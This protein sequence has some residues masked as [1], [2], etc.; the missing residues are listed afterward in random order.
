MTCRE[1]F[2]NA[3]EELCYNGGMKIKNVFKIEYILI[4]LS[5]LI[6]AFT[7]FLKTAS[8]KKYDELNVLINNLVIDC[9]NDKITDL[10]IKLSP[11]TY[12]SGEIDNQFNTLSELLR[13]S[14]SQKE[15]IFAE[16][17]L[18]EDLIRLNQKSINFGYDCLF[19]SSFF[20]L[21]ISVVLVLYKA[22]SKK[23]ELLRQQSLNEAKIKFSQ[24]L[25]D[26]VA[27]DLA[28]LKL[29]IQNDEKSK[30]VYYSEQAFK[31]VRYLIESTHLDFNQNFE[32]ILQQTLKSFEVNFGIKTEF[33]CASNL[34]KSLAPETQMEL[35]RI[36]QEALSNTSRHSEASLLTVKI[37]DICSFIRFIIED[38]GKGFSEAEI[39]GKKSEEKKHYGLENIRTRVEKLG[40]TV[41]ISGKGGT[42]IAITIKNIVH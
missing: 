11:F 31:E 19:I 40:G 26:G 21:L 1:F 9:S 7:T 25:H 8:Q 38:N 41:E 6:F 30:A 16:S 12:Y 36:L 22:L 13:N 23:N 3:D 20:L 35:L 14:D 2:P 37:T 5:L 32:E 27:Q 24:D 18:L 15:K 42:K 4:F 39:A 34:I 10:Q 17:L 29:F 33:L 28:A